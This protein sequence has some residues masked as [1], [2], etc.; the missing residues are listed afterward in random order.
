MEGV[1]KGRT[2]AP[3]MSD[4][5]NP[6]IYL[7]RPCPYCLKLRIFLTEAGMADRFT[8]VEFESGDTTHE[9]VRNRMIEA[10]LKPSFPAAELQ[11]GQ[12]TTES[13]EL[14]SRFAKEAGVDPAK[15][16]LLQ[17]YLGGVFARMGAMRQELNDLKA[18]RG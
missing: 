11:E 5:S 15:M 9:A 12:F 14:I 10:G 6:K 18:S 4:I 17:Y 1:S 8:Y 3:S 7:L 13:D 2:K 16:P